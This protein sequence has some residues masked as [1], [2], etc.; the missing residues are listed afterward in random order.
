MPILQPS[1]VV[2]HFKYQFERDYLGGKIQRI[3]V[4]LAQPVP[5]SLQKHIWAGPSIIYWSQ[6]KALVII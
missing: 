4:R 3:E 2:Y 6:V 5:Y 1:L